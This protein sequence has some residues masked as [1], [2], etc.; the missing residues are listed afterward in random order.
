MVRFPE[1]KKI[2]LAYINKNGLQQELE[3]LCCFGSLKP[4]KVIARLG[5]NT[6]C[7]ARVFPFQSA[8]QF[9]SQ[10]TQRCFNRRL[11]K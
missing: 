8:T 3:K 7:P 1:E 5:K 10:C 6:S 9:I 2:E 11:N 4:E